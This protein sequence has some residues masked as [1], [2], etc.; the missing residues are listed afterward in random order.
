MHLSRVAASQALPLA[1]LGGQD[2]TTPFRYVGPDR[3][4]LKEGL[5]GLLVLGNQ[6]L[7]GSTG[8]ISG[9]ENLTDRQPVSFNYNKTSFG[10]III[11]QET[12][13]NVI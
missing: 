10:D 11:L 2:A 13:H 5:L 6:G 4:T 3:Q 7:R 9:A 12:E 1:D 8:P